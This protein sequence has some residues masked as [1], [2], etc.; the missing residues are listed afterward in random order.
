V[1]LDENFKVYEANRKFAEMNRIILLE[2]VSDLSVF[3]WEVKIP[4][5]KN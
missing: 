5:E 2:E 3:D 1:V 4:P